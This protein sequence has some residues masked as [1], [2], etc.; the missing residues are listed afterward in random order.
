M[1]SSHP[2]ELKTSE[3]TKPEIKVPSLFKNLPIEEFEPQLHLKQALVELGIDWKAPDF[4][5][6][7]MMQR[8]H[9]KRDEKGITFQEKTKYDDIIKILNLHKFW[10]T[11]PIMFSHKKTKQGTIKKFQ[12]GE[13]SAESIELPPGFEWST[14]DLKD[15][16]LVQEIC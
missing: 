16:D 10:E 3:D 12:P 2:E 9:E 14:F 7:G 1:E 6:E 8:L 5:Y 13:V 4:T 15:M 11:E